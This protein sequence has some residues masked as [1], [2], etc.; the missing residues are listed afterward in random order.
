MPFLIKKGLIIP[1][2]E[3]KEYKAKETGE[4]ISFNFLVKAVKMHQ[5]RIKKLSEIGELADFLFINIKYEKEL[6]RWKEMKDKEIKSSLSKSYKILKNTKEWKEEEITR[7]LLEEA[8][9][10]RGELLWPLRVALSGKK[11]ST[12]PFEI[13]DALGKEKTTER[14][15]YALTK[16][17]R[18]G[19][20]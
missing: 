6:L 2:I 9:E 1:I 17:K 10:N 3:N 20:I 7:T 15:N 4:T 16:F 11:S 13:A 12:G 18:G 19:I 5:E 14:L 8:G